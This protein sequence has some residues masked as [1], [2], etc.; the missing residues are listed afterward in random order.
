MPNP[1][2]CACTYSTV[3][4]VGIDVQVTCRAGCIL[5]PD[6]GKCSR[7]VAMRVYVRVELLYLRKSRVSFVAFQEHKCRSHTQNEQIQGVSPTGHSKWNMYKGLR[8]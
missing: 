3:G 4:N 5:T 7:S 8:G 2:H 6:I 1:L